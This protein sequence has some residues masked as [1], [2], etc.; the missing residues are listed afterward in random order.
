MRLPISDYLAP[1][2]SYGRLLVK[3]SLATGCLTLTT[4]LGVI[5][6]N[7]RINFTF[8]ET[9]MIVLPDAE[10][11]TYDRI[12]TRL[13]QTPECDGRTDRHRQTV[14]QNSSSSVSIMNKAD[15]L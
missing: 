7:F 2:P 1:C 11:R 12:L 5:P 6:A 9:R 14:G 15:A 3:F 10:N 8:P 13:D 4:S